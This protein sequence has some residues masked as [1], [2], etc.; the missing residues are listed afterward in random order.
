M[1]SKNPKMQAIIE[2]A[3]KLTEFLDNPS[4]EHFNQLLR[5]LEMNQISYKINPHLVR[6]LDYYCYTVYEWVAEILGSAQQNTVC[7]GGRYDNLVEQLGGSATP[8]VGFAMGYERVIAMLETV[9][10]TKAAPLVYF[11]LVGGAYEKGLLLAEKLRQVLP[12]LKLLANC[13]GG[14]FNSQFK[15]ADKSGAKWALI[16]GENELA[17]DT[18][19]VK[20]LRA[21]EEQRTMNLQQLIE[22]LKKEIAD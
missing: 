8:A 4:R 17:N 13:G 11:V 12:D 3:P 20:N 5:L 15:R 10:Q 2:G 14:S 16:L 9:Y 6:G 22:F 21:Y 1:D 7:A 19:S 18:I